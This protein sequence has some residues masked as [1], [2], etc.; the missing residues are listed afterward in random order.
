MLPPAPTTFS[1]TT[2]WPSAARIGS[3]RM[4]ASASEGPPAGNG[5]IMVIGREG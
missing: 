3:E 1:I 2:G 5:A 4:R